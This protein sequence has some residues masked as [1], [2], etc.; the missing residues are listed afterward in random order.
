MAQCASLIQVIN[1]NQNSLDLYLANSKDELLGNLDV[2]F[3]E[4]SDE[5]FRGELIALVEGRTRYEG[6]VVNRKLERRPV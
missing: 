1:V 4:D 6:E 3:T 2:I 5:A